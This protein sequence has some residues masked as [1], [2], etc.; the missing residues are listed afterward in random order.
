MPVGE[1]T[2]ISVI[3]SPMTSMPT[4]TRPRSRRAGPI[5]AQISRSRGVSDVLRA[6]PPAW[7]LARASPSLGMRLTAPTGS[8]SIRMI[9]LS[10]RRI[11]GRYC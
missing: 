2:L 4:N 11:S 9:R 10:P 6:L 8:P 5:A 7:K 3:Q 1:V